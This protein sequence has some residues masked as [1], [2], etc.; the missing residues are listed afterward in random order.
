MS[1]KNNQNI[2]RRWHLIDVKEKV[3]G[4]IATKI[5]YI[6]RGKSKPEFDPAKDLGDFVVVI[7]AEKIELTRKKAEKKEYIRHTGYLGGLKRIKFSEMLDKKPTEIIKKAV[8]GML[9]K[10][11]LRRKQISRLKIY[12]GPK[13]PHQAQ[14]PIKIK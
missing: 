3:L 11:K 2:K 6:L 4:R 14:E 1:K 12:T 8:W 13:H 7:N 10:N 9:P 5:V